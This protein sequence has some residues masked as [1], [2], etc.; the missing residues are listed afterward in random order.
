MA[1]KEGRNIW[2]GGWRNTPKKTT[3]AI[4]K[5][6][7]GA[8]KPPAMPSL[9]EPVQYLSCC[10]ATSEPGGQGLKRSQQS[11]ES[12]TFY[13]LKLLHSLRFFGDINNCKL[14]F[15]NI[16]KL[17]KVPPIRNLIPLYI[18]K[19]FSLHCQLQFPY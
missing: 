3:L 13:L 8:S 18:H 16:K 11:S 12:F 9:S 15:C 2:Q 10:G 19:I 7:L 17:Q 4:V 14:C 1:Y 6:I 5:T